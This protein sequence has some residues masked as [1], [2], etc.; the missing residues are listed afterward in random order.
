VGR[1]GALIGIDARAADGVPNGLTTYARALVAALARI[2]QRHSYIVIRRP[3]TGPPFVALPHVKE[4]FMAGDAST[5]TLGGGV[6]A[7]RLDLYHSLHHFLPFGLNVPRIVITVHDL[8]WLEH[9]DLIR[10]GRLAA[11]TRW[12]THFYARLAMRYAARRADRVIAVSAHTRARFA[13]YFGMD[14]SRIA[15]VHHGVAHDAFRPSSGQQ[16]SADGPYFL[17]IGN[18]KPYKNIP[19]ALRAFALC[20]ADL[21]GVR[22]VI[23]GRGDSKTGLTRLAR[24]LGCEDRVIFAGF[25]SPETL[26]DRLHGA[27]ALVFPSIVEGF[28]LP[29][30]EAMAAGCP[31]IGSSCPTVAE[32]AG[33]AALLCDPRRP[34]EF[35]A[36]MTRVASDASLR[37]ELRKR[38][39]ARA[40]RFGWTRCAEQTLCV[41]DSVLDAAPCDSPAMTA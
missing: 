35:A 1:S 29:V 3:N 40:S 27:L 32:V 7:L 14:P 39:I 10:S 28:G 9:R 31:V 15:V 38:G 8:I 33:P 24:Q 34:E 25:T 26:L 21:P 19:T 37:D 22:L 36:A 4:I 30:L 16:T 12:A 2:D 41:Y 5:P 18:S 17:C 11:T 20:A 23:M 13:A 6:S